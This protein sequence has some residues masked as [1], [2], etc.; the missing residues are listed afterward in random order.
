MWFKKKKQL[1]LSHFSTAQ[2]ICSNPFY[3]WFN[4]KSKKFGLIEFNIFIP[5]ACKI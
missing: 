2:K 5:T 3:P 1:Y 4:W